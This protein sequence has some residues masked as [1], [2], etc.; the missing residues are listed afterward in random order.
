MTFMT[1]H[2]KMLLTFL[3]YVLAGAS[4]KII[5][6]RIA[7]QL[8]LIAFRFYNFLYF[9]RNYFREWEKERIKSEENKQGQ[10]RFFRAIIK[11]FGKSYFLLG[12]GVLLDECIIRVAQPIFLRLLIQSFSDQS[13]SK[14]LQYSY[15]LGV[16]LTS[17]L[18]SLVIHPISFSFLYIGMKCRIGTS[19]L[20]Y[21][22][23][24]KMHKFK[25][26]E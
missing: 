19:S 8:E 26:N 15:A 23:V 11:V 24:I 16:C 3:G 5:Q 21:R 18:H 10:P 4:N 6:I 2:V 17:L 14:E 13:I 22:K 9:P 1:H 20:I 7:Q 25:K 12:I